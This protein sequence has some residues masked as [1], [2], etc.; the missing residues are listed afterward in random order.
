MI[1]DLIN[2]CFEATGAV[3]CFLNV[4][5]LYRDKK[6][7]GVMWQVQAF[8]TAWGIWN[9]YYYPSLGQWFSFIGGSALVTFNG[10]WVAGALYYIKHPGDSNES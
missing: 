2:G 10:A 1:I 6:V 4:R 9:L 5:R 8:F 3:M 7:A